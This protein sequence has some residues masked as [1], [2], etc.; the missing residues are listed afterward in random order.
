MAVK[1]VLYLCRVHVKELFHTPIFYAYLCLFFVYF[2]Q[3]NKPAVR[4]QEEVGIR[5]NAWG[6]TVGV[7]S[8]SLSTM[9]LGLGAVMLFSDLPLFRENALF[10]SMRC[11]R[12][13]WLGGRV[14][15]IVCVSFFYALYMMLMCALTSGGNFGE[16]SKWGKLLNSY[17]NGYA[18]DG[19]SVSIELTLYGIAHFTPAEA[20]G[21]TL[22]MSALSVTLVGLMML[23]LSLLF[24]RTAALFGGSIIAVLDFLVAEKLAY[25]IYHLSP[26]SFSRLS[27]VCNPD[28]P[29]YPTLTEAFVIL[30]IGSVICILLAVLAVHRHKKFAVQILQEQF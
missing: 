22:L 15:Y 23:A 19:Y 29:Y 9:V 14:L 3:L 27:I 7:F 25:W 28:M 12:N 18:V 21:L 24:G 26:L 11:S 1:R 13:V 5:F 30:L 2:F 20:F 4:L 17:A 10:E 8:S 16:L 6:Y